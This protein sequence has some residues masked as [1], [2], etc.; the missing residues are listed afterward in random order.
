MKKEHNGI[1]SFWKFMFCILIIALHLGYSYPNIKYR[2]ASGSIGVDFF[3]MV[4]GYLFCSKCLSIKRFNNK[5]LGKETVRFVLNKIKRFLPYIIFMWVISIPYTLIVE[6]YSMADFISG[7]YNLLYIPVKN[8]PLYEI[9]GITWYIT[10]MIIVEGLLYPIIIKYKDNFI[11]YLS[12]LIVFFGMGYLFIKFG[13]VSVP[14]I[15][16]ILSYGGIIRGLVGINIGILTYIFS[17]KIKSLKLTDFS[18]FA[19]TLIEIFGYTSIFIISN[20]YLAHTRFDCLMI[21]IL[22]IAISISF[23]DKS[24]MNNFSKNKLF[25]ALEKISLPI[26]INQW[27]LIYVLRHVLKIYSINLSY[28]PALVLLIAISIIIAIIEDLIIKLYHKNKDKIKKIFI[29]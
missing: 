5:K 12:P 20:K 1:I 17:K 13:T 24:L 10:V 23:S 18:R 16:S 6:K 29:N 4:S 15:P 28:Y 2:F 11:Y 25:Y 27:L 26:F 9:Y 8:N 3:F 14:W 19:I 7:F 21:I 22:I